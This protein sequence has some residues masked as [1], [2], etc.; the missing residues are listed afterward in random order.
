MAHTESQP[1]RAAI[2]QADLINSTYLETCLKGKDFNDIIRGLS[3][4]AY[5]SVA[6]FRQHTGL[7]D[8]LYSEMKADDLLIVIRGS[9][10]D[11]NIL[12]MALALKQSWIQS[13]LSRSLQDPSFSFIPVTLFVFATFGFG[14]FTR[15]SGS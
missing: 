15:T 12:R 6:E 10:A 7:A 14:V 2:L 3:H 1:E 13:A 5:Q 4:L 11:T 9:E 8:L